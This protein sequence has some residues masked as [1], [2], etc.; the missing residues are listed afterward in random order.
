MDKKKSKKKSVYI[1]Y[2]KKDCQFWKPKKYIRYIDVSGDEKNSSRN[3]LQ[4]LS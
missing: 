4:P 2:E 1:Y 3:V